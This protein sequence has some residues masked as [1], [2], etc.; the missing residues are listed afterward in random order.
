MRCVW[1]I[2]WK[3]RKEGEGGLEGGR[4]KKGDGCRKEGEG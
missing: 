4:K 3:G 2:G 1:V